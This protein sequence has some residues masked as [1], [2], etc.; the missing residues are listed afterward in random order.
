MTVG[1]YT[2]SSV[3][4]D[5]PEHHCAT[6]AGSDLGSTARGQK[7]EFKK[8][9]NTKWCI[10][11][12]SKS[13]GTRALTAVFTRANGSWYLEGMRGHKQGQRQGT[14]LDKDK[15]H[16]LVGL[17]SLSLSRASLL[18]HTKALQDFCQL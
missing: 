7:G 5:L 3:P 16:L 12:E 11:Q 14:P 8:D 10:T 13:Q 1:S 18:S 4:R 9:C 17:S 6:K 2:W 15:G